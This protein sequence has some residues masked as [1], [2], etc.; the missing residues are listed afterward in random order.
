MNGRRVE[1]QSTGWG[2][3]VAVALLGLALAALVVLMPWRIGDA[4]GGRDNLSAPRDV[5]SQLQ[6][7]PSTTSGLVRA[8]T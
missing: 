7:Q 4:P 6:N 5:V 8:R 3:V 2:T 1:R